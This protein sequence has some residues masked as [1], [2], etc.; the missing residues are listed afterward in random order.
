MNTCIA[1]KYTCY[2]YKCFSNA[3]CDNDKHTLTNHCWMA[4]SLSVCMYSNANKC[5]IDL[6]TAED[7]K[8]LLII[9][10]ST[11]KEYELMMMIII[12]LWLVTVQ[13]FFASLEKMNG[14]DLKFDVIRSVIFKLQY[15]RR[16]YLGTF[17]SLNIYFQ[18]TR[19][20]HNVFN[21]FLL[22]ERIISFIEQTIG[23]KC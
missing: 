11:N 5:F 6:S 20:M 17:K 21:L 18:L 9:L 23:S 3:F 13:I 1:K 10:I 8:K 15:C 22:N 7:N 2:H 4:Y 19:N 12:L 16:L 14:L